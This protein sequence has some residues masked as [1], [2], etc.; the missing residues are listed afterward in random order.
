MGGKL[1]SLFRSE[2]QLRGPDANWRKHSGHISVFFLQKSHRIEYLFSL[3]R[4]EIQLRGPDA[5]WRKNSEHIAVFFLQKSHRIEYF[6][7]IYI[8]AFLKSFLQVTLGFLSFSSSAL[9]QRNP[10]PPVLNSIVSVLRLRGRLSEVVME[11]AK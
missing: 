5:N 3:F 9:R 8:A 4:S 2:I 7:L 1:N 11:F 6:F 10:L